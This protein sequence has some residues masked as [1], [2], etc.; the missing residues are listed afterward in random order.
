MVWKDILSAEGRPLDTLSMADTE[1]EE[2]VLLAKKFNFE[3]DDE[4]HLNPATPLVSFRSM[5]T[6]NRKDLVD[7]AL[8]EMVKHI[9]DKA[10]TAINK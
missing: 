5:L 10:S 7:T 2:P 9:V 3:D 8:K 4:E 1:L 6:N